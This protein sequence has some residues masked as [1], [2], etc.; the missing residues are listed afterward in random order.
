MTTFQFYGILFLNPT[1]FRAIVLRMRRK[2][3]FILPVKCRANTW[4]F[5][6]LFPT[7]VV[8]ANKVYA[9]FVRK[10]AF[11]MQNVGIYCKRGSVA[12]LGLV[13]LGAAT[14]GVTPIFSWK[15]T[16]DLFCSSLSLLLI[17]L[18]SYPLGVSPRT[19]FYLFDF[20][21]PI[22]FVNSPT[23][24]FRSGVTPLEGVTR[25]GPPPPP[26]DATDGDRW[27]CVNI[28]QAA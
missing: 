3:K 27:K 26:S 18:G 23:I 24:F 17:L 16:D 15:K 22:Y 2:C 14:E 12:S 10:T 6:G 4:N 21:C 11:V 28:K 1:T 7:R 25:G 20:V 13:S 8:C 9:W 5:H 19:F